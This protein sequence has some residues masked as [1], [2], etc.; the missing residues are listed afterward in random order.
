[1]DPITGSI[2]LA[3]EILKLVNSQTPAQLEKMWDRYYARAEWFED[4]V[5]Q[6]FMDAFK[7]KD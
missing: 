2:E 5:I 7:K 3:T 1:M 4:N 6:P